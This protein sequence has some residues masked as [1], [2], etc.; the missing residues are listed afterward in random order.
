MPRRA[1]EMVKLYE[2]TDDSLNRKIQIVNFKVRPDQ[3]NG[4]MKNYSAIF[5]GSGM[6]F[7]AN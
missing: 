2:Q 7:D 4:K 6:I 3:N 5:N 1:Q